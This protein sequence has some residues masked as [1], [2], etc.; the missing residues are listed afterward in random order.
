MNL[1]DYLKYLKFGYGRITDQV[2]IH[3][4]EK[5]MAR[6]EGI[7]WIRKKEYL[8][9]P[10]NLDVF[11]KFAGLTYQE[12]VSKIDHYVIKI[13]GRKNLMVNGSY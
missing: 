9:R 5:R 13:F 3:I 2:S 4:R 1:H 7:D 6:E 11:L 10:K 8:K 12:F